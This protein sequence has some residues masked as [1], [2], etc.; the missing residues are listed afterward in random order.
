[1]KRVAALACLLV[2]G[3]CISVPA[4]EHVRLALA[5][6]SPRAVLRDTRDAGEKV[7]RTGRNGDVE[8]HLLGDSAVD[9]PILDLL[10]GRVAKALP[11]ASGGPA[12][13]ISRISVGFIRPP[14]S[15]AVAAPYAPPGSGLLLEGAGELFRRSGSAILASSVIELRRNGERFASN[16][17]VAVTDGVPPDAALAQAVRACLA[18]LE[19][20]L[21]AAGT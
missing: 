14:R 13:E 5:V 18:T 4:P 9:P 3:G 15:N 8:Y 21:S 11:N 12:V 10:A 7:S 1:M 19:K 17:T 20:Q 16:N 6:D 2:L